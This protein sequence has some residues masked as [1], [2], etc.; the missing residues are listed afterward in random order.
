MSDDHRVLLLGPP[1]AG[2]G[3]QGERLADRY[4]LD[5]ITTGD[6][7]RNNKE[8]DISDLGLEYDTPGEYMDR[9]ELVP[10]A[11]VNEIV[12]TALADADGFILDG[13]PRNLDQA[14]YLT[15]QTDL[16]YVFFL[17]V[18]ED[19]LVERLTGRR[20]CDECG[21][22]YHVDFD[23]PEEDGVCGECGGELVQREDDT[24]E[25]VRERL[26][27]YSEE[28]EPVVEHYREE[29]SL[30]EISGEGTPDD[31][32]DRLTDEIEN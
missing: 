9:G 4:D 32:F 22:T 5:V 1:G 13:Y 3:T 23:P 28:T 21:A 25:T 29:G 15:E 30:V 24:E 10:D 18:P 2:K 17:D 19:V 6:A 26:R 12:V 16:D 11:V 7:L 31:V 8:M 20:V 27:V 14:E